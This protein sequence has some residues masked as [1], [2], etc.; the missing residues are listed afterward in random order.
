M[1][2]II[3]ILYVEDSKEDVDIT[4]FTLK[5][6][7]LQFEL[8]TVASEKEFR[9][10]LGQFLPDLVLSDHS[11]P[12]FNS[13]QGFKILKEIAPEIPFILLTGS[14]SEQFAVDS[15]L[16][17]VDDYILK[18]NLIRLPS[19]IQ[20]VLAKKKISDEKHDIE[21][22]HGQLKVAYQ[23]IEEKNRE[24]T[25]SINYASR[26]QESILSRND[27]FGDDFLDGFVIYK[28]RDIVSG[29]LY[30][31]A[32][33]T[34]TDMRY[35]PLKIMAAVDCTGHG[36]PG[37]FMSLLVSQLLNQTLKNTLVNTP[38]DVLKYLNE[39]LPEVLNRNKKDHMTD[40]LDIGICAYNSSN[41][42]V[43]FA[44]ANRPLW[45]IRIIEEAPVLLEFDGTKASIGGFGF[46]KQ[47]F[48]NHTIIVKPGDR[49]FL[50]TDGV[51][52]QFGG[53]R[54]KKLGRKRLKEELLLSAR[55]GITEQ[56]QH[57]LRFIESWQGELNQVDDML[58]L[59]AE[60]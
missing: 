11:L 59:C 57:M 19:S 9:D 37:A 12:G 38:A 13:T 16:S 24:I 51:T 29:D 22:L 14:V 43:Y 21:Q 17:G 41:R 8:K 5:K 60:I 20:R 26:I 18:T 6:S 40:G 47:H 32:H 23:Q 2:K 39:K 52:D 3:R 48:E 53:P 58:L 54:G 55:L 45:L 36:V 35:L 28:P 15:L 46:A 34:T 7:G 49:L 1:G 56:K 33:V 42:V 10:A 44:G 50:F 25:D 31:L 4:V 27:E 30:W